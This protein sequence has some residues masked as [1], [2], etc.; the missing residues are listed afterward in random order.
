MT[1]LEQ[2]RTELAPLLGPVSEA[3]PSGDDLEGSFALSALEAAA[4]EPEEPGIA[5]VER[6]DARNWREIRQQ[7]HALLTSSKD[8]RVAVL[9]TRALLHVDG[10]AGFSA[11]LE[12]L[13]ALLEQ[14]WDGL[15]PQPDEDGDPMSRLN[16]LHELVSPPM[17]AQLR[18]CP[19]AASREL[20]TFD[21][22]DVLVALGSPLG[23]GS[24]SKAAPQHVLAALDKLGDADLRERLAWLQTA[25]ERLQTLVR[26][27]AAET[28]RYLQL[29]SLVAAHGERAGALDALVAALEKQ[30]AQRATAPNDEP[31]R[32]PD[33]AGRAEG[34]GRADTIARRED[35]VRLLDR[36]CDYYARSEPSS[37][38]PLLLQRAKRLATMDFLAIV[39]DLADQGLPQVALVAGVLPEDPG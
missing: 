2:I 20:G 7:A 26:L 23:R 32:A 6:A 28:G 18:H 33:T 11:G 31:D 12:L 38:V 5:G 4:L 24:A 13:T 22:N 16:A 39:R 36:I 9:L 1:T 35:V 15:Y 21:V 34:V 3:A 14:H 17:L 37:P 27:V 19:L 8:L 25:R 30:L 10:L 29:G